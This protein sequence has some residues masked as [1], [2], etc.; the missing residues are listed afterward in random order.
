MDHV[1]KVCAALIE[2]R[3]KCKPQP[4][5][6]APRLP[7]FE[8]MRWL[9]QINT[10]LLQRKPPVTRDVRG[11]NLPAAQRVALVYY[12]PNEPRFK[13]VKQFARQLQQDHGISQVVRFTWVDAKPEHVPVWLAQKLNSKFI[14]KQDVDVFG[15]PQG[16]AAPF[17]A[18]PF[19]LLI[20]LDLALPLPLAHT[21]RDSAAGMKVA[22][23]QPLRNEDYD[24]LF[25][26]REGESEADRW[27][28]MLAFLSTT[29]LT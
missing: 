25:E 27:Q 28:R 1:Q 15:H 7:I 16:E 5:D 24:V 2:Y 14:C 4:Q 10:R 26:P 12:A 22:F 18:E 11:V 6:D 8:P 23:R 29:Q 21:V 17:V 20:N 9:D 19:D 3:A 13:A